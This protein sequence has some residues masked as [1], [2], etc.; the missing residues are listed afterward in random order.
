MLVLQCVVACV[1][2]CDCGLQHH[3]LE[4]VVVLETVAFP[5]VFPV[6]QLPQV[7]PVLL[8]LPAALAHGIRTVLDDQVDELTNAGRLRTGIDAATT[9]ND[10]DATKRLTEA[11]E[12]LTDYT[13][14]GKINNLTAFYKAKGD[15]EYLTQMKNTKAFRSCSV[16]L[17]SHMPLN[18]KIQL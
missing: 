12:L 2:T 8:A 7:Q 11:L 14:A 1:V 18:L 10:E 5:L 3:V 15:A 13:S 6:G 16:S 4:S 17:L 9:R